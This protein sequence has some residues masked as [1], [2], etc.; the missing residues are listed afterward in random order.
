MANNNEERLN[1]F[2]K[3]IEKK[4]SKYFVAY[5]T[6]KHNDNYS[7]NIIIDDRD[8][9]KMEKEDLRKRINNIFKLFLKDNPKEIKAKTIF[10]SDLDESNIWGALGK[11][12][13]I[14]NVKATTS[15]IKIKK[16]DNLLRL[17]KELPPKFKLS[18][19]SR[20]MNII[21]KKVYHR[22][23]YQNWLK[24]LKNAGFLKLKNKTYY[25]IEEPYKRTLLEDSN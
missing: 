8:I 15:F 5:G 1:N 24:T 17:Y 20:E 12:A 2:I 16:I 18:D 11:R 19:F 21:S 22:N 14:F 23:T 25:K 7:V 10:V 9:M 4:F 3:K 6:R 13:V